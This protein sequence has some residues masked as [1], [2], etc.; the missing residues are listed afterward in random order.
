MFPPK[1]K[2]ASSACSLPTGKDIINSDMT[3]LNPGPQRGSRRCTVYTCHEEQ[4]SSHVL[5]QAFFPEEAD[6]GHDAATQQ[7]SHRH[8]QEASGYSS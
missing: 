1:A 3:T 6:S 2:G 8:A 5:G 4:E 7:D